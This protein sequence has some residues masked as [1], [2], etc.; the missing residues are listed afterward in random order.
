DQDRVL[1]PTEAV[2]RGADYLVLGRAITESP[3]PAGVARAILAT[4]R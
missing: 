1:T 2:E 3:D 4:V